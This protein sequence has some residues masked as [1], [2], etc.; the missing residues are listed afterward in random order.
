MITVTAMTLATLAEE[1]PAQL[2][3]R[4]PQS[5]MCGKNQFSGGGQPACQPENYT[6]AA[7]ASFFRSSSFGCFRFQNCSVAA[8]Q[9]AYQ[10]SKTP[11]VHSV[12][13]KYRSLPLSCSHS[14]QELTLRPH[15]AAEASAVPSVPGAGRVHG[16]GVAGWTSPVPE[17]L[18]S[19]SSKKAS[20]WRCTG[21]CKHSKG[22][23]MSVT[24]SLTF[25]QNF[26][27]F[28]HESQYGCFP[29]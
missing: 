2:G 7:V 10:N 28:S 9:C 11:R 3:Q 18:A 1:G 17:E 16:S 23:Q 24:N 20:R 6:L 12:R 21:F 15:P 4:E 27:P 22:Q 8:S 26:S 14:S 29:F 25:G 13:A 5:I 19:V